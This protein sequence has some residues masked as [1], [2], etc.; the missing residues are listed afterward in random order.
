MQCENA[1]VD[2]NMEQWKIVRKIRKPVDNFQEKS[3]SL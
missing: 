2:K 1:I 3:E